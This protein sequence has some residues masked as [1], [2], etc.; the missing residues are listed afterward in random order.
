[1]K[2]SEFFMLLEDGNTIKFNDLRFKTGTG[3]ILLNHDFSGVR[4]PVSEMDRF[5]KRIGLIERSSRV[6][7]VY[8]VEGNRK[9]R[10]HWYI[11]FSDGVASINPI[12][13]IRSRNIIW[14]E[15]FRA[16]YKHEYQTKRDRL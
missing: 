4:N 14:L 16:M 2:L 5:L 13:K 15:E 8:L 7:G 6:T 10:K 9:G 12:I 1:M 11:T 3:I